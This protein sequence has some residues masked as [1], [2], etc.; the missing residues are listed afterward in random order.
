[1][2]LSRRDGV[3]EEEK[4]GGRIQAHP[5]TQDFGCKKL[6]SDS[7]GFEEVVK[8][9]RNRGLFFTAP[10]K[11]Q[12]QL[13]REKVSPFSLVQNGMVAVC[14][15]VWLFGCENIQAIAL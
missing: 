13:Q 9:N 3:R 10:V 11:E 7:I 14:L 4:W 15:V 2:L 1:M 5:Y 8:T 6:P 12:K